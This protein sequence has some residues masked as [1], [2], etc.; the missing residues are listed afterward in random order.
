M[1]GTPSACG[2]FFKSFRIIVFMENPLIAGFV[3][4]QHE[5]KTWAWSGKTTEG[6]RQID[7]PSSLPSRAKRLPAVLAHPQ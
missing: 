3:E 4:K 1:Q 7:G 6:R 5:V 2:L